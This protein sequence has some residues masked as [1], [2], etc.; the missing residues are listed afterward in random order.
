[1]DPISFA[2]ELELATLLLAAVGGLASLVHTRQQKALR[3]QRERHHQEMKELSERHHQ[4]S[5]RAIRQGSV[6]GT[7]AECDDEPVAATR[8]RRVA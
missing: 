8:R 1:M 6:G 7:L 3:R 5:L 4:E 2:V